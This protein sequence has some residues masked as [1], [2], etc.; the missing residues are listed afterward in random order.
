MAIIEDR[1]G[2]RFWKNPPAYIHRKMYI[3]H[4]ANPIEVQRGAIPELIERGP[5][6]YRYR[7]KNKMKI[8]LN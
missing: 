2:H 5:Y 6:V 8:T 4:C 1:E 7:I 3:W